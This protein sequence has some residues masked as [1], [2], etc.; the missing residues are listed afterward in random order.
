VDKWESIA[1]RKIQEAMEAGVFDNLPHRG[2]PIAL[3]K[4]PFEDPSDWMAH[5][6]LRVNGFAP[7]WIEEAREIDESAAR[8]RELLSERSARAIGEFREH[9]RELNRHILAY[10][11]K[12]PSPQLHKLPLDLDAEIQ[13]ALNS[14]R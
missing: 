7:A 11:L 3:D 2:K 5:H 13:A 4:N 6:L 12:C 1:E 9:G 14:S 10:N 8:L